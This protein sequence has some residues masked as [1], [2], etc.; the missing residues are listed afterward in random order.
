MKKMISLMMVAVL[1]VTA[2]TYS[3]FAQEWTIN[4]YPLF[5]SGPDTMEG[6]LELNTNQVIATTFI[7]FSEDDDGPEGRD[8]GLQVGVNLTVWIP[9]YNYTFDNYREYITDDPVSITC[10]Y[11]NVSAIAQEIRSEHVILF[12][13]TQVAFDYIDKIN[14]NGTWT[15]ILW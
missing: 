7:V 14:S 4:S 1:L 5:G 2:M 11:P 6:K 3:A 13:N 9:C 10:N 12:N 8:S 15:D